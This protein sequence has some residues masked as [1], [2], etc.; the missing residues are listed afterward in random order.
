MDL[1]ER[2][3]DP[4]RHVGPRE[5]QV[6]VAGREVDLGELAREEGERRFEHLEVLAH[7]AR[8]DERVVLVLGLREAR[9]PLLGARVVVVHIRDAKDARGRPVGVALEALD[10]PLVAPLV[11]F[12]QLTKKFPIGGRSAWPGLITP[13]IL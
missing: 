11:A 7:V 10:A 2:V 12:K 6:V 5:P 3:R 8:D 1:A 13:I 9:R 4:R